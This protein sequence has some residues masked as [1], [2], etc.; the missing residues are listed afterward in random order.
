MLH[1]GSFAACFVDELPLANRQTVCFSGCVPLTIPGLSFNQV[2]EILCVDHPM[3]EPHVG[4]YPACFFFWWYPRNRTFLG[5][6]RRQSY[7]NHVRFLDSEALAARPLQPVSWSGTSVNSHG[8]P[9][10][11]GIATRSED[12][13][14]R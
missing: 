5:Q 6:L 11:P 3:C 14:R 9:A 2:R 4:Q 12:A 10:T 13:T 1:V 8:L 7:S